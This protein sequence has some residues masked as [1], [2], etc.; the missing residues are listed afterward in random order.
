MSY[1]DPAYGQ[2]SASCAIEIRSGADNGAEMGAFYFL[3]QPQRDTNL[4]VAL[5]E[6]LRFGLQAGIFDA[7]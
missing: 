7:T 5:L 4:R 3:K 2:L 1:G 6:Y